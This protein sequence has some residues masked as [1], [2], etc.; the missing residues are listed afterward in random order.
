MRMTEFTAIFNYEGIQGLEYISGFGCI[1]GFSCS[2]FSTQMGGAHMELSIIPTGN[3]ITKG[4]GQHDY[5]STTHTNLHGEYVAYFYNDGFCNCHLN[6]HYF[7]YTLE[8]FP[9]SGKEFM[10]TGFENVKSMIRGFDV[11]LEIVI[12]SCLI[13]RKHYDE[14]LDEAMKNLVDI[15]EQTSSVHPDNYYISFLPPKQIKSA[16]KT[17]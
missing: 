7:D 3:Y 14:H 17:N 10:I 12:G 2:V 15:V 1:N 16:R 9:G 5:I 4:C 13:K 6:E 11:L 8:I